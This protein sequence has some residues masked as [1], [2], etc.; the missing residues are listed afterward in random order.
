MSCPFDRAAQDVGNSVLL[1]HLNLTVPDQRL[2]TLFYISG[3]GLTRDPWLVTGV[4]NMWVN[5]GRT[6]FHL[7]IGV[8][9][10]VRGLIGLVLPDLPAVLMRLAKI[11]PMLSGTAFECREYPDHL[12]L[13]CPWGNRIRCHRP[14]PQRFGRTA[15]G[16]VYLETAVP[17]G[18]GE[19]V[20][21][22]YREVL[23]LPGWPLPHGPGAE[24]RVGPWQSL[25]FVECDEP[26]A[27]YDGHH[28]QLYL[29]DFSGPH[30]RLAA[31][32]LI[33]EESNACQY[34]FVQIV[35]PVDGRPILRLE[36]EIRSLTHPLF[37][38]A[39]VNRNPV[40]TPNDFLAGQEQRPWALT[41]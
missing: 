27:V 14:D 10:R 34:R 36:H 9:Q 32:D 35:D 17:I 19:G 16:I 12:D 31:L 25:R 4:D 20:A 18:A 39:L 5:A 37:G 6:Q 15:L 7:P 26:M 8:A 30:R 23:G 38:R 11:A 41:P 2:A 1:E 33:S 3:L 21:R 13:V 40:M 28:I 24:V 22:F 29:A